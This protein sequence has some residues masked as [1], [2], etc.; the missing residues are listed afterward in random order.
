MNQ[1]AELPGFPTGN[2]PAAPANSQLQTPA[3]GKLTELFGFP[4][5][6]VPAAPANS[7]LQTPSSGKLTK[8]NKTSRSR[9]V[10][11]TPTANVGQY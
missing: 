5:G 6:N 4:S 11:R 2:V 8:S 9:A 1:I 3:S 7:Q 10:P